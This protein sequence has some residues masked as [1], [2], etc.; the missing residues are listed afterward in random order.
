[1]KKSSNFELNR[2]NFVAAGSAVVAAVGF[3][4]VGR[5]LADNAGVGHG[6]AA[7]LSIA[8]LQGSENWDYLHGLTPTLDATIDDMAADEASLIAAD[9]LV[10]GDSSFAARGARVKIHGM[11][12]ESSNRLPRMLLKARYRPYHDASHIAWGFEDSAL[13]GAQPA[14]SF[15]LP[16]D[17]GTGLQLCWHFPSQPLSRLRKFNGG[18]PWAGRM[19][20]A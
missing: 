17:T 2:R 20:S 12:A 16:V 19:A 15:A 18:T 3:G 10:C 1:M 6:Q 8:Y 4:G 13:G 14:V 5:A 7:R 11:I 9:A